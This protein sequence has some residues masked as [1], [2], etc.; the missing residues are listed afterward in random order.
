MQI[1]WVSKFLV[2]DGIS[3]NHKISDYF[4][5]L[6]KIQKLITEVNTFLKYKTSQPWSIIVSQCVQCNVFENCQYFENIY[7]KSV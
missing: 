1:R 7:E 5:I 6:D 3:Q 4:Q 2:S